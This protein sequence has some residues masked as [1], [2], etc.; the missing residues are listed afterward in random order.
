MTHPDSLKARLAALT[1][2][3]A[4]IDAIKELGKEGKHWFTSEQ[5]TLVLFA[6]GALL[7]GLSTASMT[8]IFTAFY[9]RTCYGR[10]VDPKT[11][12]AF[13]RAALESA[14]YSNTHK[15]FRGGPAGKRSVL[16]IVPGKGTCALALEFMSTEELLSRLPKM[17]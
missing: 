5:G 14:V 8:I 11:G 17:H 4:M 7:E 15:D 6:G 12:K 3:A 10:G 9:N 1:T 16:G 2:P 13:T